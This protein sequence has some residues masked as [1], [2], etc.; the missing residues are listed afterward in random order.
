MHFP[1]V[2]TSSRIDSSTRE[3]PISRWELKSITSVNEPIDS[4]VFELVFPEDCL[5]ID[6][7]SIGEVKWCLWGPDNR[8]VREV[9]NRDEL[10]QIEEIYKEVSGNNKKD[11]WLVRNWKLLLIPVFCLLGFCCLVWYWKGH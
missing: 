2:V 1:E 10:L 8:P 6:S 5:V 11:S 7:T 3:I 4:R 9:A